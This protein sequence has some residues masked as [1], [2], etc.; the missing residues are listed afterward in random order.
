MCVFSEIE[1]VTGADFRQFDLVTDYSDHH[2]AIATKRDKKA[3]DCFANVKSNVYKKIMQ[4]WK[5]LS[6]SLPETIYVRTYEA[7]IDLLRAVIIGAKGTPYHDGLFFFDIAFPE[8]YPNRPPQVHYRSFGLRV[9]PNLYSC[10]KV[11]LSILNTWSGKK[12]EKWNPECSSIL[13]ILVSIQGLVLNA[14]PYDNE[15]GF[16]P[17]ANYKVYNET[18]FAVTCKTMHLMLRTPPRNFKKLVDAHFCQRGCHIL[19]AINAYKNGAALVGY[20]YEVA[21]ERSLKV[22]KSFAK[23]LE[24]LYK[25]LYADFSKINA[26]ELENLGPEAES[27]SNGTQAN[28]KGKG[29]KKTILGYLTSKLKKVFKIGKTKSSSSRMS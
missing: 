28:S 23:D 11:C 1:E 27:A 19:S 14:K 7:R 8:D 4:E 6:E 22:S 26:I 13:Q 21:P 15:P 12:C 29:D 20:F 17:S 2:F 16:K 18:V 25:M 24:D 5:I 10:G 9:N 3:A